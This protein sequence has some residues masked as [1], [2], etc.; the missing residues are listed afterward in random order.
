MIVLKVPYADKDAAKALGARWDPKRKTWYV[1][2]GTTLA[3]FEQW[4]AGGDAAPVAGKARVDSYAG[5][6]VVGEFYVEL[7]HAC[8]PFA[9]CAECRPQLEASG[10]AAA[11]KDLLAAIAALK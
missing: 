3:P 7:A 5:K 1:Q 11:R 9:E 2:E 10:W 8:N 4:L 6:P